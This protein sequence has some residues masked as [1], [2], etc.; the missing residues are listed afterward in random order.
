M[1]RK[2][3]VL[4]IED[5][6]NIG[7]LI[8]TILELDGYETAIAEDGSAAIELVS[9]QCPDIILLDMEL[10]DMDGM[11]LISALRRRLSVPILVVSA[12]SSE[13]DKVAALE[14]GA[15]DYISKPFGNSELRARVKAALRRC[16][17]TL[18]AD[19]NQQYMV[20][21]LLI[22]F[23]QSR[24]YVNGT[25][26][27]LTQNEFRLIALLSSNM[28]KVM[29]YECIMSHLWGLL[30]QNDNRIVRVNIANLRRKI[31]ENPASPRYI[32]TIP[33]VGYRMEE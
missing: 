1:N 14:L 20:G 12:R 15:D 29:T 8:R 6:N 11:E 33:G 5:D 7:N 18:N 30:P 22:D 21:D 27:G 10:P 28:G 17:A 31:G 24:V 9:L 3:G 2:F 23:N 13:E 25:D 4:I 16:N 26:A 32:F 19:V